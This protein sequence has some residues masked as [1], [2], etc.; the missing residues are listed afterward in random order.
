MN[1]INSEITEDHTA[2]MLHNDQYESLKPKAAE[3]S[4][5]TRFNPEDVEPL[6]IKLCSYNTS[7]ASFMLCLF[8]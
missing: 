7:N 6:N 1:T 4:A 2:G 5:G 8:Q 3:L